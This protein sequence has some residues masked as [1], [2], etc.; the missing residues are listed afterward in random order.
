MREQIEILNI[1]VDV[2]TMDQAVQKILEMVNQPG[3]H[4]I[5][6]ANA[7]MIMI[8][9]EN[10]E[11]KK[12]LQEA[13][14]V[15]P[16]GAGALWAAEQ[17]NKSFPE[18]VAGADLALN[19]LKKSAEDNIPVYC[20]GAAPGVVEVAIATV[21]KQ[22]GKINV[23]GKHS[24][25]FNA[26]EEIEIIKDIETSGAKIVFVALGVPKQE[27]WL[28]EKLAHLN[29]VVGIGVGGTFDV[30]SGRIERAPK[31]MQENRLEWLYRLYKQPQ[32]F[33][34]MLALPKFMW[35]VKCEKKRKVV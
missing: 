17:Q 16:D 7:E 9:Q 23:V 6:T 14:L 35:A 4:M 1:P 5:A 24:G 22:F 2:V 15:V 19:L 34:R 28:K 25:Y 32:R 8:A 11:L 30:L 26:Q 3:F 10:A 33:M 31:W 12:A 18:R 20:F 29:N 27:L 13:D 21:E